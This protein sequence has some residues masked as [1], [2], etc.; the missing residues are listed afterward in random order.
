MRERECVHRSRGAQGQF[1]AGTAY[2]ESIQ[3]LKGEAAMRMASRV[4][5]FFWSD[6]KGIRVWL[7]HDCA[8]ALYLRHK[9]R[10]Q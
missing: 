2:V 8:A 10:Q 7:C 6:A 9:E 5:P 4:T 3:R 1:Y